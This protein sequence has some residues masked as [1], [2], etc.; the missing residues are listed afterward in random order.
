MIAKSEKIKIKN[1]FPHKIFM[2][3]LLGS[4]TDFLKGCL[5]THFFGM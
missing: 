1:L 5:L 2:S 4:L 3:P